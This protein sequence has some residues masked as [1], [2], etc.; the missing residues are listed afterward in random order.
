[1]ETIVDR[2]IEERAQSLMARPWLW[3]LL[4]GPLYRLLKYPAA[5]DMAAIVGPM[6]GHQAFAHVD[7]LLDVNPH[8]RGLEHIPN[9]GPIIIMANHPTGL[10][11][12]IYVYNALKGRRPDM[13]FMA[14]ADAMR[15]I[16]A[17]E[18]IIIPVEWVK[19]KRTAAKTKQTL[20][21][22][23][24]SITD[25]RAIII[26]PSGVPAKCQRGKIVDAPWMPT[27]AA[28]A[29]KHDVPIVPLRIEG[30]N[31][32]LFYLFE[33]THKELKDITLFRELL[34][35]AGETPRLTFGPAKETI[36]GTADLATAHIRQTVDSL[37]A[38]AP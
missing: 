26:F 17:C 20:L 30:R 15:V 36:E 3:R 37:E 28:L 22:L 1:M 19:T 35:K 29:K 27:A 18:D 5:Q 25:Q 31:S 4:R 2:L 11:D 24:R 6:S 14:N 7:A 13:C 34:N 9:T 10:A 16:P 33:K 38:T 8:I 12:G 23:R 32:R 21:T